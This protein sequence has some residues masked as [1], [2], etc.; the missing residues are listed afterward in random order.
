MIQN[1]NTEIE[2]RM[3]PILEDL[4]GNL[5]AVFAIFLVD[6]KNEEVTASYPEME[7]KS[8]DFVGLLCS[9][10]ITG[11][12]EK[13]KRMNEDFYL[14]EMELLTKDKKVYTT[15]LSSDFL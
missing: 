2:A 9:N 5:T 10:S 1:K 13:A 4:K 14:T 7:S 8:L 15:R 12:E 6:I 3:K 11:F